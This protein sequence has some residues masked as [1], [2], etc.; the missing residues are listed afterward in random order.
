MAR[1]W[2]QL[3]MPWGLGRAVAAW[4]ISRNIWKMSSY[5]TSRQNEINMVF[6]KKEKEMKEHKFTWGVLAPVI[7][8]IFFPH[9]IW[10]WFWYQYEI[11]HQIQSG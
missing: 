6:I 11:K 7:G 10:T 1:A 9:L 8:S 3:E 4:N 2:G 5:K